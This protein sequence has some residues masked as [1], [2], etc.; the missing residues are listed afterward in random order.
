MTR[1]DPVG[2]VAERTEFSLQDAEVTPDR[3]GLPRPPIQSGPSSQAGRQAVKALVAT[4]AGMLARGETMQLP[5]SGT[6]AA[7][8]RMPRTASNPHTGRPVDVPASRTVRNRTGTKLPGTVKP[9]RP[10]L[11]PGAVVR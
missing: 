8:R 10:A 5:G 9:Q 11:Y 2:A 3:G 6:F 7:K 1:E 4:V